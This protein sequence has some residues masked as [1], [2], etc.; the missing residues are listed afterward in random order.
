VQA[1]AVFKLGAHES[2]PAASVAPTPGATV[3]ARANASTSTHSTYGGTERRVAS[4]ALTAS[5]AAAGE[6]I[7]LDNAIRAHADWRSKLR[8]AASRRE[9]LDAD[10]VGRDD[11][12]EL[13]KWLHGAGNSKYGGKPA[14][15][16]L[17][18]A[19]REFHVEAG[20]VARIINRGDAEAAEKMLGNETGFSR[21]TQKVTR[22]I[23]VL[24]GEIKQGPRAAPKA[25]GGRPVS[26]ELKRP[27]LSAPSKRAS[28]DDDGEW[29][30]F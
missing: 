11:C 25:A 20:K 16:N 17:V 22:L 10:T 18:A 12:C 5:K 4:P 2:R 6:G 30:S 28:P 21:A 14:F 9:Q 1:V 26:T 8:M 27:V 29:E 13:G 15:V 24:Q 23:V 7:D 3:P 19:H